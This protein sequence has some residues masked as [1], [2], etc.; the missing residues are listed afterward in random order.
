MRAKNTGTGG[1]TT[2]IR[3][4]G[5][6]IA[7]K[8]R[9]VVAGIS[10]VA[11]ILSGGLYQVATPQAYAASGIG[12]LA[13]ITAIVAADGTTTVNNVDGA[14]PVVVNGDTL[15]DSDHNGKI[16]TNDIVSY[17]ISVNYAAGTQVGDV[18]T[19]VGVLQ[20]GVQWQTNS[21]STGE[22]G[23][24][25]AST[26]T[27]ITNTPAT[28]ATLTC[29]WT[30]LPGKTGASFQ[31]FAKVQ[32]RPLYNGLSFAPSFKDSN[33]TLVVPGPSL[34]VVSAPQV[35]LRMDAD[36]STTGTFSSPSTAF[37]S[38][39]GKE[40]I[41]FTERIIFGSATSDPRG[42]EALA[43][44][45]SFD[46]AVP[47][48]VALAGSAGGT[49]SIVSQQDAIGGVIHVTVTGPQTFRAYTI[50]DTNSVY[51]K[52]FVPFSALNP[53]VNN[54]LITQI[55]NFN[56]VGISGVVNYGGVGLK[57]GQEADAA[58]T[59]NCAA[60]GGV[61]TNANCLTFTLKYST[62]PILDQ[63]VGFLPHISST[64]A[65]YTTIQYYT[66]ASQG[67]RARILPG[68]PF[69][70]IV[71][72]RN[73]VNGGGDM[74]NATTCVSWDSTLA[75]YRGQSLVTMGTSTVSS[76][77][78]PNADI[79]AGGSSFESSFLSVSAAL[80]SD[81]YMLEYATV[82]VAQ[83]T[84]AGFNCW[85]TGDDVVWE[86]DPADLSDGVASVNAVR[87]KLKVD[88]APG[89]MFG[90]QL[91]LQRPTTQV[92]LD[93]APG[94]AIPVYARSSYDGLSTPYQKSNSV[95]ADLAFV[96]ATT[97]VDK[98][99]MSSTQPVTFTVKPTVIGPLVEGLDTVATDT[100]I[101]L[102]FDTSCV[103]VADTV[104]YLKSVFEPLY[105][106]NVLIGGVAIP[107]VQLS[108]PGA[109]LGACASGSTNGPQITI[110]LGDVTA[111]GSA[112]AQR[113]TMPAGDYASFNEQYILAAQ[114]FTV[115]VKL[116]LFTPDGKSFHMTTLIS[117][118][119]DTTVA[120]AAINN[121][122]PGA[123]SYDRS[124]WATVTVSAQRTFSFD[125]SVQTAES[126][127]TQDGLVNP[128]ETFTY[129]LSMGNTEGNDY[130]VST[131]VDVLPF[132]GGVADPRLNGQPNGLAG[133]LSLKVLGAAGTLAV[134]EEG[135]DVPT[136]TQLLV[137]CSTQDPSRI[138]NYLVGDDVTPGDPTGGGNSATDSTG[139]P[140][141]WQECSGAIPSGTTA[142]KFVTAGNVPN[143]A[144][145]QAT[146][147]VQAPPL[148]VGGY[149]INDMAYQ[150]PVPAAGTSTRPV[151]IPRQG[152]T[153]AQAKLTSNSAGLAGT[154]RYDRNFNSG[155]NA[156]TDPATDSSDA[157]WQPGAQVVL[158][159][160]DPVT[161]VVSATPLPDLTSASCVVDMVT[162]QASGCDPYMA[163][164]AADGSFEFP[165]IPAGQYQAGLV[166]DALKSGLRSVNDV[167][168]RQVTN[169]TT[170][171]QLVTVVQGR[172]ATQMDC[173][174]SG[175]TG[176]V[177]NTTDNLLYQEIIAAPELVDDPAGLV[178]SQQSL[179]IDVLGND[180]VHVTRYTASPVIPDG[181]QTITLPSLTSSGGGTLELVTVTDEATA[182]TSTQV[183]YTPP[184]DGFTGPDSFEYSWC[185]V[186]GDCDTA[187]VTLTVAG[188]PTLTMAQQQIVSQVQA[189]AG[190]TFDNEVTVDTDN[191]A[192]LEG[193]TLV[194]T[195]PALPDGAVS[196]NSATAQVS[197]QPSAPAPTPVATY[198]VTVKC[199]DDLG[200]EVTDTN[201]VIVAQLLSLSA[202]PSEV[203]T[204]AGGDAP[205]SNDL[206]YDTQYAGQVTC[207]VDPAPE[208]VDW[209]T[210]VVNDDGSLSVT[211]IDEG[212]VATSHDFTVTCMDSLGQSDSVV[213]TVIVADTPVLQ[214]DADSIRVVTQ[215]D[216][217]AG[218]V[219]DNTLFTDT[220]NGILPGHCTI[221]PIDGA[222][223]DLDSA[224]G[225]VT[226][227]A[228]VSE[229]GSH[230][231]TIQ[232]WDSENQASNTVTNTVI[233]VEKPSLAT[234]RAQTTILEG[235]TTTFNNQFG[236]DGT[237]LP[238]GKTPAVTVSGCAIDTPV[239]GAS[240]DSATG[241]VSFDSSVSGRGVFTVNITCTDSLGQQATGVNTVT[242]LYPEIT[243]GLDGWLA[244]QTVDKNGQPTHD[245]VGDLIVWQYTVSNT[246]TADLSLTPADITDLLG[247]TP[248]C[249]GVVDGVISLPAGGE[250]LV[251]T[252]T[253][254][255]TLPQKNAGQ[256]VDQ[257]NVTAVATLDGV[258][259]VQPVHEG[260]ATVLLSRTGQVD[261]QKD[262]HVTDSNYSGKIDAGDQIIF[263]ITLHNTGDVSVFGITVKD[264]M[265]GL[266]LTCDGQENG[267][268]N[269]APDEKIV[270]T[271]SSYTITADD[272]AAGS[273]VNVATISGQAGTNA[274][275]TKNGGGGGVTG[276]SE[277]TVQVTPQAQAP[278]GGW[279]AS[280]S[281]QWVWLF[282]AGLLVAGGC[283][284]MRRRAQRQAGEAV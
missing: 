58:P 169:D 160:V 245:K 30:V 153:A 149:L 26:G 62:D 192:T 203:V 263:E 277:V 212:M 139:G 87:L 109:G 137:Y 195:Y 123:Y 101:K 156:V 60:A 241:A 9:G 29:K 41:F 83:A 197:F 229:P 189:Q 66:D 248:D 48:S 223:F 42:R 162:L 119:S 148:A 65:F 51:V 177:P 271:T 264:S 128:G 143:G 112:T 202:D 157:W 94:A 126:G 265:P 70:P 284:L 40:G 282:G 281:W 198:T 145:A 165:V 125:K 275:G 115:P 206:T 200:G 102:S 146:I 20:N 95:G 135:A 50:S 72:V 54:S 138:Y 168:W 114:S 276:G 76:S 254:K 180:T 237:L 49:A 242:V 108:S 86:P 21:Y 239:T 150:A 105:G 274:D 176:C 267:A 77:A 233:V 111:H 231:F 151:A 130:G 22:G 205:F 7:N 173:D 100:Q 53:N 142:V 187:L 110:S 235:T 240:I 36:A 31:W 14:N 215:T 236:V 5:G 79:A 252:A 256:A 209:A 113:I 279:V 272:A 15:D 232:C 104:T 121:T 159:S 89:E 144:S 191:G 182:E 253:S 217:A 44:P 167:V 52:F 262:A 244:D 25:D 6:L 16:A 61:T 222:T 152:V 278:T 179:T 234:V 23:T 118:S 221:N 280:T 82:S 37:D 219:F 124:S 133:G 63:Q 166:A 13:S 103:D 250:P 224:T 147:T 260:Q 2:D 207:T 12:K 161:G 28:A 92:S 178:S 131:M 257:D 120:L 64:S 226:V 170:L 220:D 73:R 204:I 186:Y 188:P 211:G 74:V 117:S 129:S 127:T 270:C 98:T 4:G 97:A 213:N 24:C 259:T 43:I 3:R 59:R 246:G 171:P 81:E 38:Y 96:R 258:T 91:Q 45:F 78:N 163:V 185:N 154:V 55:K 181:T 10:S 88:V 194:S 190:L 174:I 208:D 32:P 71:A 283:L 47:N 249:P 69:A 68:Q 251:C 1:V 57:P 8:W 90:L 18:M 34:T 17:D 19:L 84:S 216:A 75:V 107:T 266:T 164:V 122:N 158:F 106:D 140:F 132:D 136:Q 141:D 184:D 99:S 228:T 80:Y 27:L 227:T 210:V 201:T 218:V 183:K 67:G 11:V 255:I 261:V 243:V 39:D 273:V 196:V 85:A 238:D 230:V 134:Y 199:T 56:P 225:A 214:V 269:L 268:I 33:S 175:I 35:D 93:L 247:L 172:P 155:L 116:S 46:I 193:C